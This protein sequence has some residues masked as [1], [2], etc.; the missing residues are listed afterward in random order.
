MHDLKIRQSYGSISLRL[1]ESYNFIDSQRALQKRIAAAN[2]QMNTHDLTS[3]L[4]YH[5]YMDF[6]YPD[7]VFSKLCSYL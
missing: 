3:L 7:I 1:C 2:M 4:F 5:I 6:T